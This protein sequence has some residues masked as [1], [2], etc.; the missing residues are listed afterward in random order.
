MENLNEKRIRE[1]AKEVS[2]I[3]TPRLEKLKREYEDIKMHELKE[4][5]EERLS[6]KFLTNNGKIDCIKQYSKNVD[7]LLSQGISNFINKMERNL[8]N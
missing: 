8:I 7:T 5:L 4:E 2:E 1:I 6:N 3:L